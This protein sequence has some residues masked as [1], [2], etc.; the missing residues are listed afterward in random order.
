MAGRSRWI[1]HQHGAW[2]MLTVP[3]IAGTVLSVRDGAGLGLFLVPLTLT[4]FMG[5]FAFNAASGWLKAA[6][7][8]RAPYRTPLLTFATASGVLGLLTLWAAGPALLTWVPIFGVLMAPALILAA[9]R[10]ERATL[11]GALTTAAASLMTL[12]VR[13]PDATRLIAWTPQGQH[14]A[15]VAALVFG[16]FFGTVLYV[17]TNIRERGSRTFYA[18]SIAW[19]AALAIACAVLAIR[20]VE[21]WAWGVL[22]ALATAR[23]A[24]IPRLRPPLTPLRI[25]LIEIAF[26]L[27]VVLIVALR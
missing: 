21:P 13:F 10:H 15:L 7:Q 26:S 27:V 6:P 2:A 8:R 25:G 22:F 3:L 1:P 11:G 24:A 18:A 5:Y 19:H 12:V 17:K 16:Y 20:T 14:A 23:A 9:E 4:W